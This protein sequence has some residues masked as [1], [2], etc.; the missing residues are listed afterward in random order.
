MHIG[1]G[2][3]QGEAWPVKISEDKTM[4]VFQ[5]SGLLLD[6]LYE[7]EITREE[8]E[9]AMDEIDPDHDLH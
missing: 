7:G 8:Y 9:E 3:R 2:Y 1:R 4:D 5:E 6:L